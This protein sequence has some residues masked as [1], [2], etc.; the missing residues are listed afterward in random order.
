MQ[1]SAVCVCLGSGGAFVPRLMRQAQ[2]DLG[3]GTR[4]RTIL[5]DGNKGGFGRPNWLHEDSFFRQNF[6]DVEVVVADTAAAAAA[7]A[8]QDLQI[9]YLHIDADHS[10]EGSLADFNNFLPLMRRGSLITFHDTRPNA[11][12]SVTCWQAV[13]DIRAMGYEVVN[14]YQ[15]GS[16]VAIIKV[17]K[18]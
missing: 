11:H 1:R 12:P 6:P 17:D 3:M 10:R 7:F 14:L 15:L 2:R 18:A 13:D 16:G 8:A 5:V 4:T 9:D